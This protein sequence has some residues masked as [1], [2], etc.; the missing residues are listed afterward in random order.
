M[1]MTAGRMLLQQ[2]ISGAS[3]KYMQG[4]GRLR[5]EL[6][7]RFGLDWMGLMAFMTDGTPLSSL[8]LHSV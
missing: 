6:Y 7:V 4:I 2:L 1:K 5:F 8:F 3:Q